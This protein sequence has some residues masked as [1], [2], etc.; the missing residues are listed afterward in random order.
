MIISFMQ[1]QI[2]YADFASNKL[3]LSVIRRNEIKRILTNDWSIRK[4]HRYL[5][6]SPFNLSRFLEN[7][8]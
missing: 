3:H 6:L 7:E 4:P 2:R 5:Q 8:M 1:M